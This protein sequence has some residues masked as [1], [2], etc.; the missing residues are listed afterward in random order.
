MIGFGMMGRAE[1][2]FVVLDICYNQHDIMTKD[3]F[4]C[5]AMTAMFMN[6]SVPICISLYKNTYIKYAGMP[7]EAGAH[8]AS[9]DEENAEK[10][11][12]KDTEKS[13]EKYDEFNDESSPHKQKDLDGIDIEIDEKKSPAGDEKQHSHG[14]AREFNN[15]VEHST[16]PSKVKRSSSI[17]AVLP[18]VCGCM[19]PQAAP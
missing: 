5:F 3:M 1:L 7:Q 16:E 12:E 17:P 19:R 2:F 10:D 15:V 6:V 14:Q 13:N 18:M 9:H 11:P 8:G 4:V